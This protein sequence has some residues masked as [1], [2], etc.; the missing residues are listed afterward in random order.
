[1]LVPVRTLAKKMIDCL[2]VVFVSLWFRRGVHNPA[3][4]LRGYSELDPLSTCYER[5]RV[6]GFAGRNRPRVI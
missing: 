6:G 4:G 1:M 3:E 2:Q 5:E